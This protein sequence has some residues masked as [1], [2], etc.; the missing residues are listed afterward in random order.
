MKALLKVKGGKS[1]ARVEVAFEGV[2]PGGPRA[3]VRGEPGVHLGE[4]FEAQF[5][6]AALRLHA[7]PDEPGVAQYPQVLGRPGLREP[8]GLDEF[9]HRARALQKQ[10]QD[11]A[12][13]GLGEDGERR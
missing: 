7:G 10:V 12:A 2:E 1:S 13:G 8:K 5:V 11:A 6:D 4:R 3:P 9:A